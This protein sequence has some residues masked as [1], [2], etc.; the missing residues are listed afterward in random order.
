MLVFTAANAHYLTLGNPTVMNF[1]TSSAYSAFAV[2][3]YTNGS[4]G[5][6]LTKY[7]AVS[8]GPFAFLVNATDVY[9]GRPYT[10]N[11]VPFAT[12]DGQPMVLETSCPAAAGDGTGWISGT[13]QTVLTRGAVDSTGFTL[14]WLL[15]ARRTNT[16]YS[17]PTSFFGGK[18]GCSLVLNSEVTAAQRLA[19]ESFLNSRWAVY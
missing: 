14:D 16:T 6:V 7:D 12:N 4:G 5:Y 11:L 13:T 9:M 3:Q 17:P 10:G 8:G 19:I 15:G 2:A 1:S 18:I